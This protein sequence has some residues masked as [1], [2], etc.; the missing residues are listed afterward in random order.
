MKQIL[1][2]L[3]NVIHSCISISDVNKP[4]PMQNWGS[5]ALI[6]CLTALDGLVPVMTTETIV[7]ELIEV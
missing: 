6:D 4:E 3:H 5:L 1:P 7:K 2:L